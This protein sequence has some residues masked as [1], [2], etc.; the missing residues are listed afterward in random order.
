M[1]AAIKVLEEI[2]DSYIRENCQT[3]NDGHWVGTAKQ[4]EYVSELN[5]LIQI[6]KVREALTGASHEAIAAYRPKTNIFSRP[7]CTFNYCP[8][9]SGCVAGC[10]SPRV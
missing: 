5:D 8:N 2:R 10:A 9:P 4:Q 7:E 1:S 3:F 6:I